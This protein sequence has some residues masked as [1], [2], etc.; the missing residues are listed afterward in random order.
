[1]RHLLPALL[2]LAAL[3]VGRAQDD[4]T[5]NAVRATTAFNNDGTKTVTVTN[6]DTHSSEAS[7]YTGNNKLM[8]RIVYVLDDS[9]LPASG[10]VYNAANHPMYKAT[11]KRDA[12]NRVGEED[13][14]SMTDQL[15]VRYVFEFDGNGKVARIRAYDPQGNEISSN[16]ARKDVKQSLPRVQ[17]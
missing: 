7:T 4:I 16:G 11:Y 12:M 6:P 9:N 2:L 13:D 17:H 3:P 14:Y 10:T 15:I 1:M 5:D 8:Q